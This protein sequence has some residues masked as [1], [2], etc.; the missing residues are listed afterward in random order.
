MTIYFVQP[1][2][3]PLVKIGYAKSSV[4]A[5]IKTLQIANHRKLRILAQVS[6]SMAQE[7]GLHFLLRD[8]H[9]H[10]EWF[11]LTPEVRKIITKAK[12]NGD[13]EG[14]TIRELKYPLSLKTPEQIS[15]SNKRRG[16]RKM[17]RAERRMPKDQM[18]KL[19]YDKRLSNAELLEAVKAGGKYSAVSITTMW[20][21]FHGKRDAIT[22]R[23]SKNR[24]PATGL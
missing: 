6:G 3:E 9:A 24:V 20:R 23:P 16:P 13:C 21:I 1:E 4:A 17:T 8:H 5:R 14:P 19:Y 10:G 12:K 2:G 22:G 15:A 11:Y 18:A 7:R